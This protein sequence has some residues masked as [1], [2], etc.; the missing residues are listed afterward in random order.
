[1]DTNPAR[2]NQHRLDDEVHGDEGASKRPAAAPARGAPEGF[3]T[4]REMARDFGVSIRALRFYE[5][6]DLLHPKR[7]G[8]TR[9]Y[10]AH[11]KRS[12]KMVLK[13]KRLGFTL[14]EIREMLRSQD[15]AFSRLEADE[16]VDQPDPEE[17]DLEFA[18]P[19]EQI[20]AQIGYLERQRKELDAAIIALRHAHRRLLESPCRAAIA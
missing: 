5:D 4:I 2:G 14:A 20:V 3:S 15:G 7:E 9:L 11:E 18:L 16:R 8:A 12:L 1:M 6:R 10:S 17:V 19:P 13:G